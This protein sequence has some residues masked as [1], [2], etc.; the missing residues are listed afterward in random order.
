MIS[1]SDLNYQIHGIQVLKNLN[2]DI[3]TGEFYALAGENGAG[4]STL[5]KIMLDL[6]R[7][8]EQGEVMINGLDHRELVA[9]KQ[10][11]YLPEKFDIK[12]GV[13]GWQYVSF[14]FG[15][16]QQAV[17]KPK[18]LSLCEQLSL[19]PARL[20]HKTN[21][22]SKGMKQKLGLISCFMLDKPLIILDEPLSGLDPK[23]RY[24]FKQLLETER[25]N[26]RTVFYSTHMLADAEE[27]CDQ[28]GILHH[29]RIVFDGTPLQ[30]LQQYQAETLEQ[31][32][33]KCISNL[34][35]AKTA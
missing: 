18:V 27:I 30:C 17:D 16:Y 15:M 6:I 8:V 1:V 3:E 4:K 33:M 26:K 19:D 31:A 34:D 35:Q 11:T 24:Y 14:I 10:L 7:N 25:K 21:S 5:I 12:K 22:Y 20:E 2:L 28:F 9:R 23:A 32:Y 13:T 29:G